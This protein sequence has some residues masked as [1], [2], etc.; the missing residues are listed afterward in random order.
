[1][2]GLAGR[3]PRGD[4]RE[5]DVGAA[6]GPHL[7]RPDTSPMIARELTEFFA[8]FAPDGRPDGPA[9]G[10]RAVPLQRQRLLPARLLGGDPLRRRR[11]RRG[12]GVRARDARRGLGE[13]LPSGRR[14]PARARLP[15]ARLHAPL[16]RRVPRAARDH[17][18]R[19]AVRAALRRARRARARGGRP[20]LDARAGR[21][22]GRAAA[23][24][25]ALGGPPRRAQGLLRA[26]LARRAAAARPV[27]RAISLEQRATRPTPPAAGAR[28]AHAGAPPGG[29]RGD[30]ARRSTAVKRDG[31]G[32]AARARAGDGRRGAPAR[33]GRDP[34]LPARQ[35]RALD[36][37]Q[38]ADAARGARAHGQ[39]VAARPGR[40][41][42]RRRAR[43]SCAATC[44]ST[45]GRSSGPGV[46][47]LR[48]AGTA[49]TSCSPRAGTP[50]TRCCGS[51]TAARAPTSSRITSR[52]SSRPRPSRSG[53]ARPTRPALH[54][55]TAGPW[56]RDLLA[57][58][59]RRA[60]V[61][62]F[63]LGVDHDIY[64][65]RPV[66]APRGHDRLLRAPRHAARAAVPLGVQ[67]LA[68]VHRRRPG[69]ALRAVRRH[70]RW[71]CRSRTSSSA[72]PRRRSS[73]GRTRRRPSASRSR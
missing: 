2:P 4:W 52:S 19:R 6:F 59:L 43:R 1:M 64:R 31:A 69:H 3:L 33:R 40:L 66:A 27:Q 49:P 71:T 73:P 25:G 9:R 17:R 68:E 23:L 18:P 57:T 60:R 46:Q 35:R 72:S 10:R 37:L 20:P 45:S 8:G 42:A 63:D 13:G 5:P 7:P 62:S 50:S 16:L 36:D 30:L 51:T 29:R 47:G 34:A 12:P 38:P 44:A 15:A 65:P 58:P 41:H 70:S 56:L 48:R 22:D 11:L 39:Y 61:S 54:C 55:I 28:R 53:R 67:A 14:R 26:R 24:D 21:G 32:A